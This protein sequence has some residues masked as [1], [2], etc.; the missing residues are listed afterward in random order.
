MKKLLLLCT[1]CATMLA[2][3]ATVYSDTHGSFSWNLDTETGIL[4][5]SGTGEIVSYV[6]WW[7]NYKNDIRSIVINQGITSLSTRIFQDYELLQTVSLPEGLERIGSYAFSG[8]RALSSCNL[9]STVRKIG[10]SAFYACALTSVVIPEGV[11]TLLSTFNQDTTLRYVSLP[12]T[13]KYIDQNAFRNNRIETVVLAE[14]IKT[15]PADMFSRDRLKTINIPS[16]FTSIPRSCFYRCTAL[17]NVTIAAGLDSINAYA[18]SGCTSLKSIVLPAGLKYIGKEAFYG[19]GLTDISIPS[20]VTKIDTSAFCGAALLSATIGDAAVD[21]QKYAFYSCK[22]LKTLTIGS[23][24]KSI[25]DQ[26]FQDCDAL[27]TVTFTGPSAENCVWGGEV[28]FSCDSLKSITIPEGVVS[29]GEQVL[30]Y[31]K[32]LEYISVPSTI[33]SYG[34]N[35]LM[36]CN[37]LATIHLAEGLQSFPREIFSGKWGSLT[38]MNIPASFGSISDGYFGS[39]FDKLENVTIAEGLDS[40]G[41]GVFLGCGALKNIVLPEGLKYIGAQAF[42]SS[43]LTSVT[44]PSSLIS[45]GQSAFEE[46]ASLVQ[47]TIPDG[48]QFDIPS[49]AFYKC[50]SLSQ[51]SI[52]NGVRA[53]GNEAFG[54]TKALKSVTLPSTIQS[55]GVSAFSSGGLTELCTIPFSVKRLEGTFSYCKSLD[56]ANIS[57]G[58]DSL[59]STFAYCGKMQRVDIPATVKYINNYTFESDTIWK[60]YVHWLNPTEVEVAQIYANRLDTLY[61]PYGT[62]SLYQNRTPWNN[63]RYIYEMPLLKY[64]LWINGKQLTERNYQH[65]VDSVPD[66][67]ADDISFDPA[68]NTLSLHN[69]IIAP[70]GSYAIQSSIPNLTIEVRGANSIDG[71]NNWSGIRLNKS[72]TITGDGKLSVNAKG[73]GI[74]IFLYNDNNVTLTENIELTITGGTEVS[75]K[76]MSGISGYGGSVAM[77]K[78][79]G[80]VLTVNNARVTAAFH[81]NTNVLNTGRRGG[82]LEYLHALNLNGVAIVNPSNAIFRPKQMS[83][84]VDASTDAVIPEVVIG[85]TK[86]CYDVETEFSAVSDDAYEWNDSIYTVSGN[87]QQTFQTVEGCDSVVT[88]R[89]TVF[90][91]GKCGDNLYWV[92]RSTTGEL[93]I[94]GSGA[95]YDYNINIDAQAP[96][97]VYSSDIKSVSLSDGI[98]YIGRCAFCNLENIDQS[99]EIPESVTSLGAQAFSGC[100]AMPAINIPSQVTVI[101]QRLFNGCSTLRNLSIPAG[102]TSIGNEAFSGCWW[103]FSRAELVLPEGLLTIGDYAFSGDRFT[104]ITIPASVTTIGEKAFDGCDSP[105]SYSGYSK[106]VAY[107]VSNPMPLVLSADVFNAETADVD[108]LHVPCGTEEA[109]STANGWSSFANIIEPKEFSEFT[110]T[111]NDKYEWNGIEYTES[112]DYTQTFPMANGCDSIVTLHLTIV[113]TTGM[114]STRTDKIQ[115]T[116]FLRDGVLY[117][118]RGDKTYTITGQEVK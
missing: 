16:S 66:V 91:H 58:V 72:A 47:V 87:Y 106:G 12:S 46:C 14:G 95:M 75:A 1:L 42:S 77:G 103:A 22:K 68:T 83:S 101:P 116:T 86:N 27:E 52:G 100:S 71:A 5:F 38:T 85:P 98:A 89:L 65:I 53:I 60:M 23:G 9:P 41:T 55:L 102:V 64:D 7:G 114:E 88:L 118:R 117:I 92:F 104:S 31:C 34:R 29:L 67:L 35:I 115:C 15:I 24:V 49:K 40:I 94:T 69:A 110:E 39:A 20:T 6:G 8:C 50:K 2:A 113:S 44:I 97:K 96:W 54:G 3:H 48:A 11:D 56:V 80:A 19:A 105:Y 79:Y 99:I 107:Y 90:P 76:G 10:N 37:S 70:T 73:E 62:K 13:I 30:G 84:V 74:G 111:A 78:P 45:M 32:A 33:T 17:T 81:G 21:I 51:L 25:E 43:A 36:D 82:G 109:Y 28:F 26:A 108:T 18:F 93:I 4:E 63:F 57:A 59:V 112:G 61:V